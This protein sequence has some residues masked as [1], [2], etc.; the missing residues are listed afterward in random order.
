MQKALCIRILDLHKAITHLL[1]VVAGLGPVHA[2]SV[3]SEVLVIVK[4]SEIFLSVVKK[5]NERQHGLL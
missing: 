2:R 1:T 4:H 5:Y 3:D